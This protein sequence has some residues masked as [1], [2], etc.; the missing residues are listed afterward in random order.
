MVRIKREVGGRGR[1]EETYYRRP[2]GRVRDEMERIKGE[3]ERWKS[4]RDRKRKL[5]QAPPEVTS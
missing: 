5:V 4:Q 1:R 3:V 2:M